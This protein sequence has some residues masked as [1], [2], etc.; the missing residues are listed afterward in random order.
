MV[1]M[2]VSKTEDAGS[3]PPFPGLIQYDL[4]N[5]C[6]VRFFIYTDRPGIFA[7][8]NRLGYCAIDTF[9]WKS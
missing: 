7:Q 2:L 3:I 6:W 5:S 4:K 1:I 9:S 8:G